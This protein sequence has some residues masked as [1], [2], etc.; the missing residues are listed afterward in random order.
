MENYSYFVMFVIS[1]QKK[2]IPSIF[3]NIPYK[4]TYS[5]FYLNYGKIKFFMDFHR[6]I[7]IRFSEHDQ[8]KI[9][10]SNLFAEERVYFQLFALLITNKIS[11]VRLPQ[12]VQCTYTAH[13]RTKFY[14]S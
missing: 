12:T 11:G 13:S 4:Q 14:N 9:F 10:V 5:V 1:S 8:A 6:E 2:K 7:K 3:S